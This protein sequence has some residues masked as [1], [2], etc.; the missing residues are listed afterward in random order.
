MMLIRQL[1]LLL[2]ALLLYQSNCVSE[3]ASNDDAQQWLT[4]EQFHRTLDKDED[5]HVEQ[6][7]ISSDLNDYNTI[8]SK[9]PVEVDLA[10]SPLS[11]RNLMNQWAKNPVKSWTPSQVAYWVK[12]SVQLSEF[13]SIILENE[14]N[15]LQLPS[16]AVDR[17]EMLKHF[18]QFDDKKIHKFMLYAFKLVLAGPSDDEIPLIYDDDNEV[19]VAFEL[20]VTLFKEVDIDDD[21]C[22]EIDELDG[23]IDLPNKGIGCDKSFKEVWYYWRHKNI[24]RF[25]TEDEVAEW[26]DKIKLG[27]YKQVFSNFKVTGKDIP[28]IAATTKTN[29]LKGLSI[30]NLD[31]KRK[32]ILEAIHLV[33]LGNTRSSH[34]QHSF[35]RDI[36]TILLCMAIIFPAIWYGYRQR[37]LRLAYE[38]NLNRSENNL[39]QIKLKLEELNQMEMRL[40]AAS[41]LNS[42]QSTVEQ[43]TLHDL[44]LSEGEQA[45]SN[46]ELNDNLL[47]VDESSSEK[48]RPKIPELVTEEVTTIATRFQAPVQL[49]SLLRETYLKEFEYYEEK[50]RNI[51]QLIDKAK[52]NHDQLKRKHGNIL[53]ALLISNTR[54]LDNN[55]VLIVDTKARLEKLSKEMSELES[56]WCKIEKICE[57]TIVTH[58]STSSGGSDTTSMYSEIMTSHVRNATLSVYSK[59]S[60]YTDNSVNNLTFDTNL[61]HIKST[62]MQ[63]LPTDSFSATLKGNT[64]D[65]K[66]NNNEQLLDQLGLDRPKKKSLKKKFFSSPATVSS[67]RSAIKADHP[68]GSNFK[69]CLSNDPQ[70]GE[71]L[72]HDRSNNY[73][74]S[75]SVTNNSGSDANS[76]LPTAKLATQT[77]KEQA[78]EET[79][80]DMLFSSISNGTSDNNIVN[81]KSDSTLTSH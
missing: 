55:E 46:T 14:I 54:I 8:Q 51:S 34:P 67:K 19:W 78:L 41:N 45:T 35:L 4:I 21:G 72:Q 13:L 27:H 18:S 6:F 16:L 43:K 44:S 64:I 40:A 32:L 25:W 37:K 3:D 71:K 63:L 33:I 47:I 60:S 79:N 1:I 52:R 2:Y 62:S 12:Y 77:V 68:H 23:K 58:I 50:K 39:Y 29:F 61:S 5:G 7:E 11:L 26:L 42:P 30:T 76:N 38:N 57:I 56:R 80:N 70:S 59:N 74:Y 49:T 9:R 75:K 69:S 10:N 15:G 20:V 81:E 65:N 22:V 73:S 66:T 48:S 31:D 17:E 24:V 53:S 36:I 28:K